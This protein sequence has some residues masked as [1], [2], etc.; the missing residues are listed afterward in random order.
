MCPP[1]GLRQP[2][3]DRR[4]GCGPGQVHARVS[5]PTSSII[6]KCK[7]LNSLFILNRSTVYTLHE[8]NARKI[9]GFTGC[10]ITEPPLMDPK[11]TSSIKCQSNKDLLRKNNDV[12][13]KSFIFKLFIDRSV[14]FLHTSTYLYGKNGSGR[15]SLPF[16]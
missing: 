15:G 14:Q 1:C 6:Y 16:V 2:R 4:Q 10:F 9:P 11:E 5:P 12:N 7:R 3:I 8:K 13:D